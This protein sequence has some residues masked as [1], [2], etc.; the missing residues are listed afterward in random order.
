MFEPTVC[1]VDCNLMHLILC[2]TSY[3]DN[4]FSKTFSILRSI[5]CIYCLSSLLLDDPTVQGLDKSRHLQTGE[6]IIIVVVLVMWAGE[7][8]DCVCACVL[9]SKSEKKKN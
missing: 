9:I 1:H 7:L 6:M 4:I 8:E 3:K 2:P 5:V